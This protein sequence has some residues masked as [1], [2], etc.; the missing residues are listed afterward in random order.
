MTSQVA[1]LNPHGVALASDST[2]SLGQKTFNTVNKI[3]PLRP[4]DKHKVAFMVSNVGIYIPGGVQW[5]RVFNEFSESLSRDR[6][7]PRSLEEYVNKFRDWLDGKALFDNEQNS[8]AVQLLLVDWFERHPAISGMGALKGTLRYHYG[9]DKLDELT[10]TL[11]E[12]IDEGIT[13]VIDTMH[14]DYV[15]RDEELIA[16]NLRSDGEISEFE[17]LRHRIRGQHSNNSQ[18]AAKY[19]VKRHGL[20]SRFVEI[21]TDI[22]NVQ[23][24]LYPTAPEGDTTTIVAVGFGYDDN[25]P[26]M[27]EMTCGA[28][29]DPDAHLV[30]VKEWF[31][32]RRTESLE[33]RG[34]LEP[35]P[36]GD[37]VIE[38]NAGAIIRGYAYH[39]EMDNVLNGFHWRDMGHVLHQMPN[40]MLDYIEGKLKDVLE[41][42][43]GIGPAR[44]DKIW[45]SIEDLD[46]RAYMNEEAN[47][48]I[49]TQGLIRRRQKF[50]QAV[51]SFPLPQLRD[52]AHS[53]VRMEAEICQW[54]DSHRAVGGPIDVLT[55]TK[56]HGCVLESENPKAY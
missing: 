28:M 20:D 12:A 1:L 33:D 10:P 39:Y 27:C 26:V 19:I 16:A 5:E 32:I 38:N 13:K 3:F 36:V 8:I 21:L 25:T 22:F 30:T 45:K 4:K 51:E 6:V 18:K 11:R 14:N 50:R 49:Q 9:T 34:Q 44:F 55:I 43:P 15:T 53:L 7:P 46:L 2:V 48:A 23:L 42:S 56:E 52:F 40:F 37:D 47:D 29:I 24:T 54:M 35:S 31:R 41:N 17:K